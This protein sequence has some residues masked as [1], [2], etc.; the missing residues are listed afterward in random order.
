MCMLAKCGNSDVH[1]RK[2]TGMANF[3]HATRVSAT[4]A[5]QPLSSA[6]RERLLPSWK[7]NNPKLHC[8][9]AQKV[10]LTSPYSGVRPDICEDWGH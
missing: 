6:S 3:W 4:P 1:V 8:G 7:V 2:I 5:A 9:H 10:V